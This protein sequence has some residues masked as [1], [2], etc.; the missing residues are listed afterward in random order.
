VE[1]FNKALPVNDELL[2]FNFTQI[3]G[4]NGYTYFVSVVDKYFAHFTFSMEKGKNGWEI[5]NKPLVPA[6]IKSLEDE[7][8]DAIHVTE[9]YQKSN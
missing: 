3:S 6:W 5:M 2:N 4:E 1:N 7:L 9:L 8:S